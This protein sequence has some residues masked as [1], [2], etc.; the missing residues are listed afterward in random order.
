MAMGLKCQARSSGKMKIGRIPLGKELGGRPTLL[1]EPCE[2]RLADGAGTAYT[3][4]CGRLAQSV[5]HL[6]YT[7]RVGGS[8]PSP[9][10][11]PHRQAAAI[12]RDSDSA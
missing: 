1:R 12:S 2:G 7:E 10:T 4:R 8:S 5:E 6:V 3:P 11:I 9:P